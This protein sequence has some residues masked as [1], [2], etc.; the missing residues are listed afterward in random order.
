VDY[1]SAQDIVNNTASLHTCNN[2]F[3]EDADTGNDRVLGF[4][5]GTELLISWFFLRLIGTD[6]LRFKPLELKSDGS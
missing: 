4:I 1:G 6:M 3:N 2:M 5:F